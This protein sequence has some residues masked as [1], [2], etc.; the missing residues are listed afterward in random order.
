LPFYHLPRLAFRTTVAAGEN[1]ALLPSAAG[2]VDP[3]LSTGFPLTLLGI[4]RLARLLASGWSADELIA[5]GARTLAELD[6]TAL[7]VAALYAN[8]HDLKVFSAL[9]L[10]YFAAA[11]FSEAARRLHRSELARSFLL[12]DHPRFG[13]A[14]RDCC[15][16]AL[17]L[18][19]PAQRAAVI[20]EIH[21]VIEPFDIAG[22]GDR[23]RAP[24]FPA[25]AD[26]F[27]ASAGKLGA[28]RAQAEQ[29]LARA[30]FLLPAT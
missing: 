2:V 4:E 29:A 3:L 16:R 17:H 10:L 13:L 18:E 14:L 11:S 24:W 30:G 7:L 28:T 1:W 20:E 21:A 9:T 27:L 23:N 5:Y 8:L 19:T 15:T 6:A 22:L 26:D 25:R 12:S